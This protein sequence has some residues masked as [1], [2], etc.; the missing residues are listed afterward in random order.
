MS[1][2]SVFARLELTYKELTYLWRGGNRFFAQEK[3][4]RRGT[5]RETLG[6]LVEGGSLFGRIS[7]CKQ[8]AGLS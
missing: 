7:K 8:T 1:F 4:K 6:P 5:D 2:L 3:K